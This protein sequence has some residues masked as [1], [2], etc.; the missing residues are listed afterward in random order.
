[1]GSRSLLHLETGNGR[2]KHPSADQ[3]ILA[4]NHNGNPDG[5]N[6]SEITGEEGEQSP[7]S[8]PNNMIVIRLL[9]GW[10]IRL[11]IRWWAGGD[12]DDGGGDGDGGDG[13]GD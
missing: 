12:D 6:L 10:L 1:M 3:P 2:P 11:E 8:P 4:E 13:G 5:R 7:S 9:I